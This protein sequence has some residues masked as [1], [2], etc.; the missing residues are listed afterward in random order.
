LDAY[1]FYANKILN[2][3]LNKIVHIHFWLRIFYMKQTL[4]RL[5]KGYHYR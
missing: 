5:A 2:T 3:K 1:I 4:L